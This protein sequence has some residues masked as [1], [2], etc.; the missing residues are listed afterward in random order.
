M[1]PD[2]RYQL[3]K[4]QENDAVSQP[5]H[6]HLK[7]GHLVRVLGIGRMQS[8]HW[9]ET[10]QGVSLDSVDIKV[11]MREVVIYAHGGNLWVRPREEF[12]DG[13]FVEVAS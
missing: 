3:R 11:D 2:D 6:R 1:T 9:F 13:R 8:N 10:V 4:E 12:E 7:S 5:T